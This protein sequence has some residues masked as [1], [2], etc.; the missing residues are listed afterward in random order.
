MRNLLGWLRLG[1]LKIVE[2]A[3]NNCNCLNIH[4]YIYILKCIGTV[5]SLRY[6]VSC[7]MGIFRGPLLAPCML[8]LVLVLVSFACQY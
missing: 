5:Y 2:I 1:W 3:L 6:R 4:I 7:I 8:E